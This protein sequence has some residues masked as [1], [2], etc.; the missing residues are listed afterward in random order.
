[1]RM[2]DSREH[3]WRAMAAARGDGPR[4]AFAL[5][6]GASCAALCNP[7]GRLKARIVRRR[8]NRRRRAD[9]R[10]STGK[11]PSAAHRLPGGQERAPQKKQWL[12]DES[13][14]SVSAF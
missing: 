6:K 5:V 9:R 12:S 13:L 10:G 4:W 11:Q 2:V 8:Y 3:A 14:R 1:M 7:A